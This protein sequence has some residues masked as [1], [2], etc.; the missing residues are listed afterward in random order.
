MLKNISEISIK[1]QGTV[2]TKSEDKNS[3]ALRL[4]HSR[5]PVEYVMHKNFLME[6]STKLEGRF[7]EGSKG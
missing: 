6:K 2:I 7:Y 5:V 4:F 1:I 3:V